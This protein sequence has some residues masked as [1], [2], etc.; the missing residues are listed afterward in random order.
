VE[1]FL[2]HYSFIC[3]NSFM[4][5]IV[6]G[7]KVTWVDIQ[8]PTRED[9]QYLQENFRLH[10]L[11]LDEIIPPSWRTKVDV[12]PN[13]L[14][15]IVYYPV[16]NK[17]KK[18][19]RPRELDIIITRDVI[20][21]SHYNS[22]V[23]VKSLFDAINMYQDA[24]NEFLN[25]GTGHL[26][27]YILNEFWESCLLKLSRINR[28]LDDVEKAIFEGKEKEM[29][30]EISVVK[31]DIIDFWRIIG[32]QGDVLES[33]RKEGTKFFGEE[34]EHYFSHLIG[35]WS[36]AKNDL[37]TYRETIRALEETNNS[38]LTNK[39]NEIVKLLTFFSVIVFPLTLLAAIFGMN[40][41]YLPFVGRSGDFWIIT[42]IMATGVIAMIGFFRHKKWL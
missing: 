13:Y 31:A 4:R 41:E 2:G 30:Y 25:Q 35:D 6:K 18:E 39:T 9:I 3:Y 26:L 37:A 16:Y 42:G 17:I 27:Y 40:T 12:Y 20:I 19:T 14:F 22:I 15:A 11:V 23:P 38:L 28:K 36:Q 24:K 21:T 5:Y 32:P 34:M 1:Y 10:P 8:N 7:P 29:L 33:L